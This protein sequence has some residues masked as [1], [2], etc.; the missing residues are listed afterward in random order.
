MEFWQDGGAAS[1]WLSYGLTFALAAVLSAALTPR[2]RA[3]AIRFGIRGGSTADQQRMH[4]TVF[5]I[6]DDTDSP[7]SPTCE[8][9]AD[10]RPK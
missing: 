4:K 8:I 2:E 5:V 7:W 6:A 10:G 3:A 9:L 1:R